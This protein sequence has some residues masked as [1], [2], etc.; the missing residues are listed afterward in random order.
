V[1][2]LDEEQRRKKGIINTF[3]KTARKLVRD[4]MHE[5]ESGQH[6]DHVIF[7]THLLFDWFVSTN[8]SLDDVQFVGHGTERRFSDENLNKSWIDYHREH[9]LLRVITKE[10][11]MARKPG[12]TNWFILFT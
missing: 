11:N 1:G 3:I 2:H 4:Q 6:C 9:A 5:T 8:I 7:F 12:V 10:E